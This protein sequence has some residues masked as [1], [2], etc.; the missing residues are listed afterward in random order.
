M[1][2]A[3]KS[4]TQGFR[5]RLWCPIWGRR[6]RRVHHCKTLTH[7]L[8]VAGPKTSKGLSESDLQGAGYSSEVLRVLVPV[9]FYCGGVR[10]SYSD[11]V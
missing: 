2:S 8:E 1:V 3:E 4:L 11:S 9:S 10:F 5:K 6:L 7:T